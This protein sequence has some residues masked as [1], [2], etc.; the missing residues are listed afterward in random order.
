MHCRLNVAIKRY[1]IVFTITGR[2]QIPMITAQGP[3]QS[4]GRGN[5]LRRMVDGVGKV[6]RVSRSSL[7]EVIPVRSDA[8]PSAIEV[9][10]DTA[11]INRIRLLA[12]DVDLPSI[13]DD[14]IPSR[15]VDPV[16]GIAGVLESSGERFCDR[17]DSRRDVELHQ[18]GVVEVIPRI[19]IHR[20]KT[21]ACG[22]ECTLG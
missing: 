1:K 5:S 7:N 19:R 16:D 21:V 18:T 6:V 2:N 15:A 13:T 14:E 8:D 22:V 3:K 9:T 11:R 10:I 4:S 17:C 20:V 12:P